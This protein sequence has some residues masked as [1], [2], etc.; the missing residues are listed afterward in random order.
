[1]PEV[2]LAA[3]FAAVVLAA[4]A[5][6]AS[7]A[8]PDEI[9]LAYYGDFATHPGLTSRADWVLHGDRLAVLLELEAGG[10]WHPN[11]MVAL[12]ARTGPALRWTGSR[13]GLWGLFAHVGVEHGFW[14]TPTYTVEDGKVEPTVLPG[15]TWGTFATG[16]EFGHTLPG[17]VLGAWFVRPQGGLRFET[18]HNVGI[19]L[20]IAAGV[21]FQ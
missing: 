13:G 7:P 6:A 17:D 14:A 19:D 4:P 8:F 9:S 3:V 20:A 11:H 10:Y 18:F 12:L 21:T 2:P 16:L 1:V 15:D 5:K